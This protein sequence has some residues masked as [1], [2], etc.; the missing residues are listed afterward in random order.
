M[1]RRFRKSSAT[2]PPGYFAWEATG[3]R[4]LGEAGGDAVV[5]VLDVGPT[6]LE[7]PYLAE[8][9]PS[10][11]AAEDLG[12]ALARIHGAGADAFGAPPAGWDGD[13]WLGPLSEPLPLRLGSW[14]AWG[15]FAAEARVLPLARTGR[16]R[17]VFGPEQVAVLERLARTLAA[18]THDTDDPPARLHG[19]LWAGNVLWTP[20]GAVVVDPAAHGGHREADLAMLAVFGAPSLPR[21][22]AAYDEVAPLASGWRERVLLHQVHPLLV[23][24]VLFGGSYVPRAVDAAAHYA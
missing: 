15:V 5:P 16:E 18:G 1:P 23:H 17:G 12:R 22:L 3:L 21:L 24:A 10:V 19:D 6:H 7:L 8:G 14:P 13:G 9:P 2:V 20:A 4:W 11:R